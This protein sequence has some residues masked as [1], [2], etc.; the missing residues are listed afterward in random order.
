MPQYIIK[1]AQGQTITTLYFDV[2]RP[3]KTPIA[4]H[5]CPDFWAEIFSPSPLELQVL[6]APFP[7]FLLEGYPDGTRSGQWLTLH[8]VE[9]LQNKW[10]RKS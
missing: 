5:T 8:E 2:V 9:A 1:D 3:H 7:Y 4:M 6:A 10:S